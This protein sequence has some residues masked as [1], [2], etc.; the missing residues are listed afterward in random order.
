MPSRVWRCAY[1]W[2]SSV[3]SS[4]TDSRARDL[5]SCHALPPSFDSAGA[6]ASAPM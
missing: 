2:I 1:S 4:L 3:A 6:F 5:S